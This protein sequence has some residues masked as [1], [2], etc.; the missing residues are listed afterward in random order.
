MVD[1]VERPRPDGKPDQ[2]LD[3][4][5][6]EGLHYIRFG[7]GREELYD[8]LNDPL[9]A[10]ELSLAADMRGPLERLRA[11]A[12]RRLST[13]EEKRTACPAAKRG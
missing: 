11:L 9:E 10:K 6:A 13:R 5:I 4:V 2:R 7:D 12:E 1:G 3:A 8:I